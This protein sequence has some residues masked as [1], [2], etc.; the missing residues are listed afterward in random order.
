[1]GLDEIGA[2]SVQDPDAD[3]SYVGQVEDQVV[4]LARERERPERVAGGANRLE[5][6]RGR[7][8]GPLDRDLRDSPGPIQGA[9]DRAVG[10]PVAVDGAPERRQRDARSARGPVRPRRALGGPPLDGFLEPGARHDLVHEPPP[11]GALALDAFLEGGKSARSRRTR[12]PPDAEAWCRAAPSSGTGS[13]TAVSR[14]R[15]DEPVG[16]QRE[17]AAARDHVDRGGLARLWRCPLDAL[18]VS[19][20]NLQRTFQ[21]GRLV[22]HA[23]IGPGRRRAPCPR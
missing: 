6:G 1:M 10:D 2:S 17:L 20:V 11:D 9:G 23:D 12:R 22:Q 14:R 18:R 13:A 7:S 8:A 19:L 16:R 5:G 15:P 4:E 3:S 21:P